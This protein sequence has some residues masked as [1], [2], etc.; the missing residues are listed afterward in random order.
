MQQHAG[1]NGLEHLGEAVEDGDGEGVAK[2][3]PQATLDEDADGA[4]A[5]L[6]Q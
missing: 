2:G 1:G 3:H 6:A 5:A 4:R